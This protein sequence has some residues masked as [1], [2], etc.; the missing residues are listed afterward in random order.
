MA[1]TTE[2]LLARHG[3]ANCNVAGIVG[4]ERGCTRLSSRS[5]RQ[6]EQLA[7]RLAAEHAANPF[8]VVYTTPRRRVRETCMFLT[9]WRHA[10]QQF[11]K[12]A[13]HNIGRG[14]GNRRLI[15]DR[16]GDSATVHRTRL[17]RGRNQQTPAAEPDSHDGA[18][19]L[20][21]RR[22]GASPIRSLFCWPRRATACMQ[23]AIVV[24]YRNLG[25]RHPRPKTPPL[26]VG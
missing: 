14:I 2:L 3:E 12:A 23:Y 24:T 26:E 17:P 9:M 16:T 19:G 20:P 6:V 7:L 22:I 21:V 10:R 8:N 18:T 1:I 25:S 15:G 13:D 4:G 11:E 5:R